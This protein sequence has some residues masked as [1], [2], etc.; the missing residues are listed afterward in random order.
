MT[1]SQRSAEDVIK[2]LN[3]LFVMTRVDACNPLFSVLYWIHECIITVLSSLQLGSYTYVDKQSQV[4]VGSVQNAQN[5]GQ[6][7]N[8]SSMY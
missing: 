2:H 8:I 4:I 1:N 5:E 6:H 3:T 7:A